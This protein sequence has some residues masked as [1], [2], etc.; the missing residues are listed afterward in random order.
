[1]ITFATSSKKRNSSMRS[2]KYKSSS[3]TLPRLETGVG[4]A[5]E[6]LAGAGTADEFAGV[7]DG[8]AAGEDGFGRA[9]DADTLEHRIVHAHVVG[10]GADNFLIIWI[11]DY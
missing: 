8:A 1:M 10:F 11:E 9:F 4:L 7:D 2:K 6:E 3:F 5:G